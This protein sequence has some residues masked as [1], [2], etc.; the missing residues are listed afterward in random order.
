VH[1]RTQVPHQ[2][3]VAVGVVVAAI[4][5]AGDI[6]SSIGFSSFGVLVYY[7]VTNLAAL[8]L[9]PGER[10]WPAALA[11]AGVAGCVVLALSLPGATVLAGS[12]VLAAGMLLYA[13]VFASP[14]SSA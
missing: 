1:E 6:R 9:A 11:V 12:A 8:R 7:G 13:L 4:V 10:R 2:A 14:A 5:A 3:Q